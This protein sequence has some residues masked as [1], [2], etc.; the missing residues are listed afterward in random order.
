MKQSVLSGE[1]FDEGAKV[2]D[3][4]DLSV[5][6]LSDLHALR[7]H[8]D[9]FTCGVYGS[10]IGCADGDDALV[11]NFEVG[12]GLLLDASYDASA[13]P[14]ESADFLGID[15]DA[16]KSRCV[17]TE[18]GPRTLYTTEHRTQELQ[19]RLTGLF[20][21][22]PEHVQTHTRD[23]DVHLECGHAVLCAGHL[24]VHVAVMVLGTLYVGQDDVLVTFH[25]KT[26]RYAGDG[27]FDGHAG[28]HQTKRSAADGRHGRGAVG[29]H[30]VADKTSGV[31]KN[32]FRRHNRSQR[33][34][35]KRTVT[36]VA[37]TRSTHGFDLIHA[38]RR[39]VVMEHE[40]LGILLPESVNTLLV[41]CA[42][43][44]SNDH[45]LGLAAGEKC[46][47]VRARKHADLHR[48][49]TYLGWA[50]SVN[51]FGI[52]DDALS[53]N[54]GLDVLDARED[55]ASGEAA[56]P[57][58]L[59]ARKRL[60]G[61]GLY[62][63]ERVVRGA[64]AGGET[65]FPD[66]VAIVPLQSGDQLRVRLDDIESLFRF[67]DLFDKFVNH[68]DNLFDPFVTEA[69]GIE[70]VGLADDVGVG[71][72]HGD[73]FSRAGDHEVNIAVVQLGVR[74]VDDKL[75]VNTSDTYRADWTSK[76][77]RRDGQCGRSPY[78]SE[79]VGV[80]FLVGRQDDRDQLHLVAIALRKERT[81]GAVD[82]S[83]GG[84]LLGG[85]P[86]L[87][88]DKPSGELPGRISHL[89]ILDPHREEVK[90]SPR[91]CADGGGQ[92]NGVAV[93]NQRRTIGLFCNPAGLDAER[94]LPNLPLNCR[95]QFSSSNLHFTCQHFR[96]NI[97]P[98]VH[99]QRT[100]SNSIISALAVQAR[101][102]S[103]TT[104][105]AA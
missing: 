37:S 100:T 31:W 35:G 39:E 15:D 29:L 47:T 8:L 71:F 90:V 99:G 49:G 23:L 103:P 10:L 33:P 105:L 73:G 53:H 6:D 20:E 79:Y 84:R 5:I 7:E 101:A 69:D 72:D 54:V 97:L 102:G 87:A 24:E 61:I 28:V 21:S 50:A 104:R 2:S 16:D 94:M 18:L 52:V 27:I 98:Q 92:N 81:Q 43:Q 14:D 19:T 74:G 46:R 77:D 58:V 13:W 38:E 95:N 66:A 59:F 89:T 85:R 67:A 11:I 65:G 76:R 9:L 55:V 57:A 62:Q 91:R 40:A 32:L 68:A 83:H 26:H 12:P 64:L 70:H 82:E 44:G 51:T 80:V 22:I 4:D 96:S 36:Y 45:R 25:D 60:D 34:L 88:F 17:F 63:G 75:P 86:A 78:Q 1:E 56:P 48:K 41:P 93:T 3:A 30:D 42:A